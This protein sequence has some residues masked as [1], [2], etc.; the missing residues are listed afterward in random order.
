MLKALKIKMAKN[1]DRVSIAKLVK[2]YKEGPQRSAKIIHDLDAKEKSNTIKQ[3]AKRNFNAH[4]GKKTYTSMAREAAQMKNRR[5]I[6]FINTALK[7]GAKKDWPNQ[8]T[9]EDL[10]KLESGPA[11]WKKR[12]GRYGF[13]SSLPPR[14]FPL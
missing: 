13:S 6:E 5:K 3:F 10:D 9:D 7:V 14:R 12:L 2:M 11:F 4:L 1:W 8:I